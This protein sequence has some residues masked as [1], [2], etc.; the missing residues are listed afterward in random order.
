MR[1]AV[2]KMDWKQREMEAGGRCNNTERRF[3]TQ[4]PR[5]IWLQLQQ[6]VEWLSR[7]ISSFPN[8]P[9]AFYSYNRL[10]VLNKPFESLSDC[11]CLRQSARSCFL[12]PCY[13]YSITPNRFPS[14]CLSFPSV[15]RDI[16]IFLGGLGG[17]PLSTQW[18]D[19]IP[20]PPLTHVNTTTGQNVGSCKLPPAANNNQ[21][22]V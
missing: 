7:T 20:I 17:I 21:M 4:V 15:T 12:L 8:I 16:N 11:L 14:M 9:A 6:L 2:N 10:H 13:L 3:P 5:S 18:R 1:K 22:F 19:T